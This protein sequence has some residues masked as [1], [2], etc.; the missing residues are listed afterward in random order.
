MIRFFKIFEKKNTAKNT[1]KAL[2]DTPLID[3]RFS[4]EIVSIR[5][6]QCI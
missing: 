6:R 4:Q 1:I 2:I 5:G 3:T